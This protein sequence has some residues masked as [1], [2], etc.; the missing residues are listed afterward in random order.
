[1]IAPR[2]HAG[3]RRLTLVAALGIASAASAEGY[4][5]E[6]AYTADVLSNVRGGLETGSR[7][8]DNL[9]LTL[10]IDVRDAWGVGSG[11]LFAYA[12]YNNG[13]SLSDELVGDLQVISN[14]DAPEALRLYELWYDTGGETW[15]IRTGLYDLNSEFDA[16]DT[17]GLFVN[18]SH[19]IGAELGQTGEN[20]P[21]IFPVTSLAARVAY[22]REGVTV[23]FALL[24][25]VPGDP[26]RPSRTAVRLGDDDGVLA[27]A[28][29]D[30]ALH[31]R[32]RVWGGVWRY[33][34]EFARLDG[35]GVDDDNHGLDVGTELS[36]RVLNR[37]VA[38]FLRYGVANEDLNPLDAYFGAGLVVTG[39]F[40]ARPDD[41]LGVAVANVGIGAPYRRALAGE[42]LTA[43]RWERNWELTYRV[44]ITDWLTLQ[45]NLQYVERPA[46]MAE[47]DDALVVGLRIEIGWA[48]QW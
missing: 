31:E 27:I 33:S 37:P 23:R 28:E 1:M 12:L 48:T 35:G 29:L 44:P 20:G 43:E 2:L 25:G 21:S 9:D 46:G 15:S 8:L 5:F 13:T 4:R 6:A 40:A 14:I 10:G 32:W 42:G 7:Y 39:P 38:G 17:G 36:A 41:Q 18:S 26:V 3:C 11:T 16:H 24:D 22:V 47:I 34:A 19:G 30:A 45:P